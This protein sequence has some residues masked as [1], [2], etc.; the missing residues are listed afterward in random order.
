MNQ[1]KLYNFFLV[2]VLKIYN[3]YFLVIGLEFFLL[4]GDI[5]ENIYK[6]YRI[7]KFL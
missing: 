7:L 1:G 2:E 3:L 6:S 4:D 5:F